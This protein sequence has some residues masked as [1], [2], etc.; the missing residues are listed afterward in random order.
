[1]TATIHADARATGSGFGGAVAAARPARACPSA[2]VL[3]RGER[4]QPGERSGTRFQ[5]GAFPAA[6]HELFDALVPGRSVRRWWRD[7][8]GATA[9]SRRCTA[10][11]GGS[12]HRRDDFCTPVRTG[13]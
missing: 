3:E 4:W 9:G 8:V 7:R 6:L 10:H 12:G 1:M 5:D 13:R 2:V 11:N